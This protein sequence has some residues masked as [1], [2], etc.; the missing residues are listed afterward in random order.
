[1]IESSPDKTKVNLEELSR[2]TGLIVGSPD[3][4]ALTSL[5]ERLEEYDSD[6]R[7]KTLEYLTCA[8]DE[9]RASLGAEPAFKRVTGAEHSVEI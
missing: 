4:E 3:A 2:K 8:M 5:F 9:T 1:M 6:E 7:A